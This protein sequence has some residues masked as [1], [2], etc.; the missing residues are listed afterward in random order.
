[1]VNCIGGE[2]R[3]Y[4]DIL[5]RMNDY[6]T[7]LDTEPSPEGTALS[8]SPAVIAEQKMSPREAEMYAMLRPVSCHQGQSLACPAR[9]IV[10]Q[11][12]VVLECPVCGRVGQ[13]YPDRHSG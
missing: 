2:P 9:I 12:G 13:T 4:L 11:A 10:G 8:K 6:V 3:F 7:S 5:T 1:M